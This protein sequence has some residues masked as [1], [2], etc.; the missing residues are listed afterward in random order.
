MLFWRL[1]L[2]ITKSEDDSSIFA[3][4]ERSFS[5]DDS[6]FEGLLVPRPAEFR[7][8]ADYQP[9]AFDKDRERFE[10]THQCLRTRALVLPISSSTN[11]FKRALIHLNCLLTRDMSAPRSGRGW[12]WRSETR[13]VELIL[14]QKTSDAGR[15]IYVSKGLSTL[16][17]DQDTE[18]DIRREIVIIKQPEISTKPA[19][20][21]RITPSLFDCEDATITSIGF[22]LLLT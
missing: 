5:G 20:V 6:D 10:L 4:N 19:R 21:A 2:E 3:L 12:E 7:S 17:P 22:Y 14:E 16:F 13:Q 8:A 1:Q 11:T 9:Y 15:S 18:G